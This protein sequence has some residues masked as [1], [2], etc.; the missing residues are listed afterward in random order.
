MDTKGPLCRI[1]IA[2]TQSVKPSIRAWI[3]ATIITTGPTSLNLSLTHNVMRG[4]RH[5]QNIVNGS[6]YSEGLFNIKLGMKEDHNI[7]LHFY[8]E[9]S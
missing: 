8:V 7:R 1:S 2:S 4:K 9:V 3:K 6:S 5:I